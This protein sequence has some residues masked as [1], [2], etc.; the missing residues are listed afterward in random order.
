[1]TRCLTLVIEARAG[2]IPLLAVVV[3]LLAPAAGAQ[4]A[5]CKGASATPTADTLSRVRA[6]TLCLVNRERARRGLPK[7]RKASRLAKAAARHSRDMVRRGYFDHDTPE[8]R[9]PSERITAAGYRASSS[10]E[11]IAWGSGDYATPRSVV[12]QWMKS[13]GH[14]A[15]IL[16]SGFRETGMGVAIGA[17][18]PGFDGVAAATYTQVFARP[19]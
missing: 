12:G 16:R 7:L 13:K 14:R 1:V 2:L 8:G 5:T 3:L 10:G 6:A 4:A 19:R 18:M 17:P 9:T 15:N 11:N